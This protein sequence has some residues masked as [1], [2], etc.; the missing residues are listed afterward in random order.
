MTS[1]VDFFL[2]GGVACVDLPQEIA[3]EGGRRGRREIKVYNRATEMASPQCPSVF[4]EG[5]NG[6]QNRRAVQKVFCS[7]HSCLC[8]CGAGGSFLRSFLK[9]GKLKI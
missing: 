4:L 8:V 5:T 3:Q 9:G 7:G 2:G 1:P 6:G